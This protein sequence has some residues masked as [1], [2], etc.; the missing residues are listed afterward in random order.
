[1]YATLCYTV[2]EFTWLYT[3]LKTP[4]I[5][6]FDLLAFV[7]MLCVCN[8][9]WRAEESVR[10]LELFTVVSYGMWVQGT[11]PGYSTIVVK[12]FNY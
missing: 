12:S 5:F 11:E 6:A 9:L 10:D 1:M 2:C 8:C 7:F 4:F 3:F